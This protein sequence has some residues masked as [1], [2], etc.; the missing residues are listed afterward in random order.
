MRG[1]PLLLIACGLAFAQF[2]DLPPAH[3]A[4]RAVLDLVHLG[5]LTGYPDGTFQG[6]RGLTRY[7]AAL[8]LDRLLAALEA[9]ALER[10][11]GLEGLQEQLAATDRD[12]H[13]ALGLIDDTLGQLEALRAR[14]DRAEQNLP[15]ALILFDEV[16][17]NLYQLEESFSRALLAQQTNTLDEVDIR[18]AELEVALQRAAAEFADLRIGQHGERQQAQLDDLAARLEELARDLGEEGRR[19]DRE[20]L[21]LGQALAET[22]SLLEANAEAAWTL[23]A[24]VRVGV[25]GSAPQARLS[26]RASGAGT[27]LGADYA[28]GSFSVSASHA[29]TPTF[30]AVGD[31]LVT[32]R[33][34]GASAGVDALI[35]PPLGLRA[36]LGYGRG[37]EGAVGIYH[38]PDHP[39]AVLPGLDLALTARIALR[40]GSLDSLL[41]A[42]VR[43]G[44]ELGALQLSPGVLYRRV[45][46]PDGYSVV[47]GE[48]ATAYQAADDLELRAVARYGLFEAVSGP[49]GLRAP[50]VELGVT[51]RGL[52]VEAGLFSDLPALGGEA[53][54]NDPSPIGTSGP[55]VGVRVGYALVLGGSLP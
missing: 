35:L 17:S 47:A 34:A 26:L 14:L 20:M 50:E 40:D 7:E 9:G 37:V 25:L 29:F 28:P 45:A 3:W 23:S 10:A 24:G 39:G 4:E 53:R 18:L 43:L 11:S 46:T 12:L 55:K 32:D 8:M 52:S 41:A 27:T 2:A 30:R 42:R 38:E 15:G 1:L 33:G 51:Y 49:G 13:L 5:I 48:L 21:G 36:A 22:R 44:L 16:R 6:Q 19:F 54:F 31:Y